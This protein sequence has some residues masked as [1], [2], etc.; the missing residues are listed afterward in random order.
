[1]RRTL[2]ILA[3]LMTLLAVAGMRRRRRRRR[4]S[5]RHGTPR[6]KA[7]S[8]RAGSSASGRP[9]ASTRSTRS[10]PSAPSPTP[11]FIDIYPEL[12]QYRRRL[13]VGGRL[14][15]ELGDL[16][17]RAHLDLPPQ[18]GRQV[19]GR[20]AA[21][22]RG[23][24]LDRRDHPQVRGRPAANL[25]PFLE[26][27]KSLA[28]PDPNTLVITY[29]TADRQRPPAAAAVLRPPE[30]RLGAACGRATA[31]A[32]SSTSRRRT[33]RSSRRRPVR[34]HEVRQEGHDDPGAEPGLLRAAAERRRRRDPVVRQL[35]RDGDRLHVGRA[36]LHRASR[37][38]RSTRSRRTPASS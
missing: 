11:P 5:D 10:L 4:S 19:V 38:Q 37:S 1:M 32:S 31:R 17:R 34:A 14:G 22:R 16:P 8:S 33:C 23:R 35:G 27:V 28:A 13:R 36:R 12:V 2:A 25:A 21:H 24:R 18:A 15:R 29:A 3:M 30:A 20:H 6:R 26:H 9:T 7:R